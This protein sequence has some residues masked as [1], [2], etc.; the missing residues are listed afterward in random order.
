MCTSYIVM[1]IIGNNI[2]IIKY[3]LLSLRMYVFIRR[4][5][6]YQSMMNTIIV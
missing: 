2:N 6:T 3:N 4:I 5:F 1:N